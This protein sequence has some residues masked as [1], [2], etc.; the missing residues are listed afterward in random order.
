MYNSTDKSADFLTLTRDHYENFPVASFLIPKNYRKDI[1]IVYWFARTADDIADEGA[2]DSK[3]RIEKL[4]NFESEFLRSLNNESSKSEFNQLS[5]TIKK[6]NLSIKNFTDLL[7][8]F[9]QDVVQHRYKNYKGLQDYCR[10]SANPVGRI[11][12]EIF[13]V[14]HPDAIKCSDK[15]CT[16]L[17]L[18]NFY[19]DTMIDYANGRIYYPKDEMKMFSVTEKMF[20]LK[21]N[22]SNIKALL[23]Y[24][25]DRTQQLFD[26]GR[27]IIGYLSGRFKYEILWTVSGG[28]KILS[29]IRKN[30]YDV[31]NHRPG[32]NKIDFIKL[33]IKS[34]FNG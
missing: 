2:I 18:T 9:K 14:S 17:Q 19:Q 16:A 3:T 11:L 7:S 28:E 6:Y 15:I 23:K 1:A 20:E 32:L 25:V 34:V 5:N 26:E 8:A 10:R 4:D 27:E 12:L 29:K 13:K 21:E 22:N 24:N 33:L 31:L 30:D